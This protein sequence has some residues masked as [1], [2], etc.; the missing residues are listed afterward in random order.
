MK[1]GTDLVKKKRVEMLMKINKIG[2]NLT[3]TRLNY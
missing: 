3:K 1:K 2:K